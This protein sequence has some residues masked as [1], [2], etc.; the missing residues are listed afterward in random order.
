MTN[1]PNDNPDSN[2]LV[3][4]FLWIA[5]TLILY[6]ACQAFGEWETKRLYKKHGIEYPLD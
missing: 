4:F 5:C 6:Y 3:Q 1:Q 2:P